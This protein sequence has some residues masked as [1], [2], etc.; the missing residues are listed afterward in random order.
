VTVVFGGDVV[1][2]LS[3]RVRRSL[4]DVAV[5]PLKATPSTGSWTFVAVLMIVGVIEYRFGRFTWPLA[6][7][8]VACVA[9]GLLP[10]RRRV[11]L[12]ATLVAL[13]ANF[14]FEL[15]AVHYHQST[16]GGIAHV[17][18]GFMLLFALCRWAPPQRVAIGLVSAL[19]MLAVP[20]AQMG[21]P[22]RDVVNVLSAWVA[23]AC[24]ALAMRYRANLIAQR[25]VDIRLAERN[26]L[27]REL[28]DS[29]A[30]HVSAIA[31]QAQAAR[32]VASTRPEQAQLALIAI[33]KTANDTIA[34]MRRMVG[35]LRGDDDDLF[36]VAP[37][38][39]AALASSAGVPTVAVSGETDLAHLP[40]SI[41]SAVFRI[42]QEAVTNARSHSRDVTMVDVHL[43]IDAHAAQLVVRNDGLPTKRNAGGGFGL[44]GMHERVH[45]LGG[46]LS[47]GPVPNGG[48][49]VHA[50]IPLERRA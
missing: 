37:S 7:L 23:L 19:V 42:A 10:F 47:A 1:A 18:A 22:L 4:S 14:A 46:V 3:N 6:R 43:A 17:V 50:S 48:W 31:V 8:G 24:F 33:E 40:G 34:E 11:P 9:F 45:A 49:V 44:V 21:A 39:L 38:G 41:A 16:I 20:V 29:V 12:T 27:A 2:R 35:I 26:A 5:D 30:H 15:C 28:H 25:L 36:R 13:L 32:F